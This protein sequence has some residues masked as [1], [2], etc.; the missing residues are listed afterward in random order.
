VGRVVG[1]VAFVVG[2]LELL[3]DGVGAL[4]DLLTLVGA[5]VE[6]FSVGATVTDEFGNEGDGVV[7]FVTDGPTE[8]A[9]IVDGDRD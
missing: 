1:A 9:L 5:A 3:E 4:V 2:D 6:A 8:E 7:S